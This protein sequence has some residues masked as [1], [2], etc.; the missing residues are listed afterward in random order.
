MNF[1]AGA[2]AAALEPA[3]GAESAAGAAFAAAFGVDEAA[4][5]F[6]AAVAL[7]AAA[8]FLLSAFD[9][10]SL[11]GAGAG[12]LKALHETQLSDLRLNRAAYASFS[13]RTYDDWNQP[14]TR[15]THNTIL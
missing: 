3:L 5:E 6:V 11:A 12:S 8:G 4:L 13:S 10:T 15:S 7:A 14:A 2:A 1:L 9:L